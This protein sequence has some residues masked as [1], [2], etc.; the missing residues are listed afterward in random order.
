MQYRL[1]VY[2]VQGSELIPERFVE[3]DQTFSKHSQCRWQWGE[4]PSSHNQLLHSLIPFATVASSTSPTRSAA[5]RS[6]AS[7][8]TKG[9][10]SSHNV[11][12]SQGNLCHMAQCKLN[13]RTTLGGSQS[14]RKAVEWLAT[15]VPPHF[16]NSLRLS[17]RRM[18]EYTALELCYFIGSNP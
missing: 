4:P 13:S 15:K 6:Q 11:W 7:R 10:V 12:V 3:E 9:G 17:Q 5:R 14:V 2:A 8:Q 16:G 1:I 18:E